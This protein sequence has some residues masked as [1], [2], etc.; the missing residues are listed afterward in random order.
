MQALDGVVLQRF[1]LPPRDT[2][3]RGTSGSGACNES[4]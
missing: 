3:P 1:I 2:W 4:L